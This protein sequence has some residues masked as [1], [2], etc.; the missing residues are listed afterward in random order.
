MYR[1]DSYHME[2]LTMILFLDIDF[3]IDSSRR[4][5]GMIFF[6]RI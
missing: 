5:I 3:Q 2:Q 6:R 1:E 4:I